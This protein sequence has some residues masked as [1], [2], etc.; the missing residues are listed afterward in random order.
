MRNEQ[1]WLIGEGCGHPSRSRFAHVSFLLVGYCAVVV[2][3]HDVQGLAQIGFSGVLAKGGLEKF[4]SL[5]SSTVERK[6]CLEHDSL[7]RPHVIVHVVAAFEIQVSNPA[8]VGSKIL[9]FS[10]LSIRAS[11]A[12][13]GHGLARIQDPMRKSMVMLCEIGFIIP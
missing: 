3:E 4:C 2:T 10:L 12:R 11:V 9:S 13:L 7:Y 5:L 8:D 6:C 1:S